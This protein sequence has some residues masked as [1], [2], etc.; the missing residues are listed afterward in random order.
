MKIAVCDN[1]KNVLYELRD[2]IEGFQK[3]KAL[4]AEI[5]LCS[6]ISELLEQI[7][8]IDAV[9]LDIVMPGMDGSDGG[10][11]INRR[12]P[13]C[14]IIMETGCPERYKESF[15][16]HARRFVTKPFDEAEITEALQMIWDMQIGQ[17]LVTVSEGRR[18]IEIPQREICYLYT[19]D[20]YTELIVGRRKLQKRAT[21]QEMERLLDA[22]LFYR[23]H[24]MYLVNMLRIEVYRDGK[25]WICGRELKVARRKRKDFERAYREFDLKYK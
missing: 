5:V 14:I 3:Q 11:Y 25:I 12:N 6:G 10:R 22:R 24:K 8:S 4:K 1:E 20:S 17:E 21:L 2:L 19:V 7:E 15:Y 16:I 13:D 9:F 18:E 23:I